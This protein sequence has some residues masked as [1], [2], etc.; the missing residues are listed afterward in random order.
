M[1]DSTFQRAT[2]SDFCLI[3]EDLPT[4]LAFYRDVLGFA[5]RRHAP[6]FADFATAG[7]T[8]ALWERRHLIEH[9]GITSSSPGPGVRA[10][11]SAVQ[12][13]S[14]EHVTAMH[15]ALIDRGVLFL[16]PPQ[17]YVWNAFACYF[18]DPDHHLWEIYAWG[19]E[20]HAGLFELAPTTT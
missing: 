12:V 9:V 13:A 15:H 8:L 3:V 1:H 20:G 17:W 10:S 16:K 18:E 11:M 14:P 6:G 4:A 7:V 19:P 2:V 5:L